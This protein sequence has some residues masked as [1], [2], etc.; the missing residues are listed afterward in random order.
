MTRSMKA[1]RCVHLSAAVITISVTSR[2]VNIV[3]ASI[4]PVLTAS[5]ILLFW[6]AF[7]VLCYSYAGYPVLVYL[8]SKFCPPQQRYIAPQAQPSLPRVTVLIVAYN[9]EQHIHGRINNILA[10]DYP[11]DRIEVL[12]ASDGSTDATVRI[13]EA[14]QRPQ[15]RALAFFHRRGKSKTLVDAVR[16]IESDIILFTDATNRFDGQAI[17]HLARHFADPHVGIVTGKVALIDERGDPME[18]LY[19]NM[20]MM[21]RRSEM[22]LGIMLGANGPIYAI[23]RELFVAPKCPVINDDFVLPILTHLRHQCGIVYD[24]TAKAYMLSSGGLLSEFRRRCR[25]GAGAYQSLSVLR[26]LFQRRHLKQAAAFISHKLMRWMGPFLLVVLLSSSVYLAA[27]PAYRLLLWGQ[28]AAYL[29]AVIGLFV[30]NRGHAPRLAR[31]AASFLVLNLALLAG[32]FRWLGQPQ[33][34]VWNPTVRPVLGGTNSP[35]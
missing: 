31:V 11:A 17:R 32:F 15:V 22:R 25:I 10:C 6:S 23:R 33:N 29:I 26:E 2:P 12:V 9:A 20:E 19:W 35:V 4:E 14:F 34:V 1:T 8:A 27:L 3:V 21:T 5:L 30:P 24:E 16:H 7:A 13:V 18:S 28:A